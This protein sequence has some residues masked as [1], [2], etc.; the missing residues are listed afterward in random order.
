MGDTNV[1]T[2]TDFT[3]GATGV[4]NDRFSLESDV[5][6]GLGPT[7]TA[8]EIWSGVGVQDAND[9]LQ[10]N[11]SDGKLYYDADANG[12]GDAVQ[13][14]QL[15]VLGVSLTSADFLII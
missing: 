3:N 12:A 7:V 11:S 1:D 14:A 2:I 10:Y 13:F 4:N 6:G 9:M 8:D 15:D 5:F